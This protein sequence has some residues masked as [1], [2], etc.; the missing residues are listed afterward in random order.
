MNLM[1]GFCLQFD[2]SVAFEIGFL[3]LDFWVLVYQ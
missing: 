3:N 1:P 2:F